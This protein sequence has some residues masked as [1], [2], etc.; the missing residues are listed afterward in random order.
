MQFRYPYPKVKEYADHNCSATMSSASK[1]YS[2]SILQ[3][4]SYLCTMQVKYKGDIR[5]RERA[6]SWCTNDGDRPPLTP[7]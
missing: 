2:L 4:G 1:C 5:T 6:L 7:Y 3:V